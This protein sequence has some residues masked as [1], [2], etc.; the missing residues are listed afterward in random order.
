MNW[1]FTIL[2]RTGTAHQIKEPVGWDAFILNL[3]RDLD[4]HGLIV[5]FQENNFV[6]YDGFRLVDAE[7]KQYGIEAD[8]T[9]VIEW[10]CNDDYEELHRGKL[11]FAQGETTCGDKCFATIS[12]ETMSDIMEVI[13]RLDQTVDLLSTTAFDGTTALTAYSKLGFDLLLPSKGILLQDKAA[14]KSAVETVTSLTELQPSYFDPFHPYVRNSGWFNIVPQFDEIKFSEIGRFSAD[15][16]PNILWLCGGEIDFVN[17]CSTIHRVVTGLG[18]HNHPANSVLF[19]WSNNTPMIVNENNGNNFD[20]VNEFKV[21]VDFA[22]SI[23]LL[24]VDIVAFYLIVVIRRKDGTYDYLDKVA[25]I[26]NDDY[27]DDIVPNGTYWAQGS[28]N[29]FSYTNSF[30]SVQMGDGDYLFVNICGVINTPHSNIDAGDDAFSVNFTS[31][32]FTATSLSHTKGTLAKYFMVNEAWSRVVESVSNNKIKAYSEYFGRTDS[33]PYSQLADGCGSMEAIT[34]GLFIRRQEN[35]NGNTAAMA[36]SM[37]NMWDGLNPIHHLGYGFEPD[38]A[39]P[40]FNRLRV[41][42]WQYFY[43]TDVV[44]QCI[45]VNNITTKVME[46]DHY[47]TVVAGYQKWAAED[48]NGLDEF[49]TKRNMRTSLSQIKNELSIL[50]EFI[51]SGYATEI[52]RRKGNDDSKDWRYDNDT[53]ITCLKKSYKIEISVLD[54]HK[55]VITPLIPLVVGDTIEFRNTA[56]NDGIWNVTSYSFGVV[57]MTGLMPGNRGWTY[58]GEVYVNGV[59]QTGGTE[60]GVELGNIDTPT[61]II[62]PDTIYNFRISPMRNLMRWIDK[63]FS[64][65]RIASATNKLIFMDGD[66]NY[67]ASGKMLCASCRWENA[68]IAEN[69]TLTPALFADLLKATPLLRPERVNYDFKMSVRDFKALK[70]NPRGLIY[71]ENSKCSGNAWIDTIAYHPDKGI[72]SFNLIPKYE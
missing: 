64:G 37:K 21:D 63:I 31:G 25:V 46:K 22:G 44:M 71:Y 13:N 35:H 41:E 1:R 5:D 55:C 3:K 30:P 29:D 67:F 6:S 14:W 51:A 28:T 32:S 58:F 26:S 8:L 45:G 4:K 70:A 12:V 38:P 62:D 53:F 33:Q 69:V 52:T 36:I 15:A 56:G 18:N 11:I 20:A 68:V 17:A 43:N 65:Y 59:K 10:G 57:R 49:L 50:S 42:P 54:G 40:G 61:N 19:E 39:R 9:L 66:G 47:S 27:L 34:K 7:Y 60:I 2:D 23:E 24:N 72:A 48:Y 16:T